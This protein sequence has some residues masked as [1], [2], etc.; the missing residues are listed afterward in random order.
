M[1]A[2]VNKSKLVAL[3]TRLHEAVQDEDYAALAAAGLA[4]QL[5]KALRDVD[6]YLTGKDDNR[7]HDRK[8]AEA[9]LSGE[10]WLIYLSDGGYSRLVVQVVD[11]DQPP[12]WIDRGLSTAS[13]IARW[14]ANQQPRER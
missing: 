4:D 1:G 13:A 6:L 3:V 8:D 7:R 2:S 10:P 12:V 14:D 11:P 9:L 5:C